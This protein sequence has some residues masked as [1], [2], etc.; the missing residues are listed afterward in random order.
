[1]KLVIAN[2]KMN[3]LTLNEAFR[4]VKKYQKIKKINIWIAPPAIFLKPLIDKFKNCIFG[5]QNIYFEEKGAYTGE[6][7]VKMIKN[8]GARFVIINHSERRKLG[9][10]LEIANKKIDIVLKNNLKAVVCLGEEKQ[11]T[12]LSKLKTEWQK[13]FKI[14]F[15][16]IDLKNKNIL[17]AYEPT[18]AISTYRQGSVPKE[19]VSE[20]IQFVKNW[21]IE[22]RVIYGGSVFLE[23]IENYLNLP[24]LG[25]LIGSQSLIPKNFIKICQKINSK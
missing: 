22:N 18:W 20:F 7:S 23:T 13:Q 16:N 1:M 11:I 25:F 21:N 6:I 3:P 12:N 14:L 4:L 19:I 9:E 2:W 24:L 10:N 15:K 5:A 17:I 8:I